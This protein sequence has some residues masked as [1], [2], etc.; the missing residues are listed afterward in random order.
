ME[1]RENNGS[2][3]PSEGHAPVDGEKADA[4]T[5]A[6]VTAATPS[7]RAKLA[8]NEPVELDAAPAAPIVPEEVPEEI[9]EPVSPRIRLDKKHPLAIRWMHWI[10]FPVLFT[11]IWSG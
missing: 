1:Q 9:K 6:E 11:M 5:F 4:A 3:M 2:P 10:N 7:E 8:E